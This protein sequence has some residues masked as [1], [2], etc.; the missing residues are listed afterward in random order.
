MLFTPHL[1]PMARGILA[2]CYARPRTERGPR[3]VPSW[4]PPRG[5]RRRAVRGRHRG[6][7]LD[8]GHGRLQ[9]RPVR[10]GSIPGPAGSSPSPPSTTSS[11]AL[12]PGD[13]VC[14]RCPRAARDDRPAGGRDVPVSVNAP[15]GFVAVGGLRRHQGGQGARRRRRGHG[16][17]ESGARRRRVHVQP[18][19]GGAGPFTV[20]R[21][22]IADRQPVFARAE[23]VA[24]DRAT[25]SPKNR[26]TSE[27]SGSPQLLMQRSARS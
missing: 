25:V 23:M 6:P 18:G 16:R 4:R 21:I 26:T 3:P 13:P 12:G 10:P 19:G 24:R 2:T 11:R 17:R 9:R 27:L 5:L 14:Q 22:E 7:A 8:Q 15:K 20:E 1:A